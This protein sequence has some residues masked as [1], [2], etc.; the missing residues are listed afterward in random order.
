MAIKTIDTDNYLLIEV[1][2]GKKQE[3][4][5]IIAEANGYS[6]TVPNSVELIKVGSRATIEEFMNTIT[7]SQHLVGSV[8]EG[9]VR[10]TYLDTTPIANPQTKY[11]FGVNFV[12]AS[13]ADIL[14]KAKLKIITT[15]NEALTEQAQSDFNSEIAASFK[16][17]EVI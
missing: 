1:P 6:E 14:K 8:E 15:K 10:L 7:T 4:A 13:V 16:D 9:Q 2:T 3:L 11:D 12:Y 5:E 17:L